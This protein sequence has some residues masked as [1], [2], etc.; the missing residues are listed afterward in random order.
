MLGVCSF[1]TEEPHCFLHIGHVSLAYW[2][3]KEWR[4]AKLPSQSKMSGI[5]EA[6]PRKCRLEAGRENPENKP[7]ITSTPSGRSIHTSAMNASHWRRMAGPGKYLQ[8]TL[9]GGSG[10]ISTYTYKPE[11]PSRGTCYA[12][13]ISSENNVVEPLALH[14]SKCM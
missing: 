4:C 5:V 10:E 9:L 13:V 7:S 14:E 3:Y 2:I 11:R 12:G 1:A 6:A 8:G